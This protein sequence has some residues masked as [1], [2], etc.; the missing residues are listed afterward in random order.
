MVVLLSVGG[1]SPELN[2]ALVVGVDAT[3]GGHRDRDVRVKLRV[4]DALLEQMEAKD[5]EI[6]VIHT[7]W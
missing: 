5:G 3:V 7:S 2:G 4:Q 1:G 6:E